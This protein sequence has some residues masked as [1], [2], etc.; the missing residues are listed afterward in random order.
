[1]VPEVV[2]GWIVMP[3][4]GHDTAV[5]EIGVGN[6]PIWQYAYLDWR[7]GERIAKVRLPEEFPT[8]RTHVQLRMAGHLV[9]GSKLLV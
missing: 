6:P 1:V 7:E 8:G 5:V 9:Y 2:D 4:G 3:Y